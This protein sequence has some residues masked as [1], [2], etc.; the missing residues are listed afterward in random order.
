[1]NRTAE[2]TRNTNETQVRVSINLDGTGQQKLNTG[3][4]FLDH[5]LDQ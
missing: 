3:V 2:I 4:P 1:M 5:M